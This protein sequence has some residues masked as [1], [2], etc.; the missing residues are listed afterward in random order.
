VVDENGQQKLPG[1]GRLKS[2]I[3]GAG[4]KWAGLDMVKRLKALREKYG[5]TY[6]IVG[7]G[8][9]M[10]PADFH[11][12]LAA[13]ADNVQSATATIWNPRLAIEIKETL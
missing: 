2:G 13:G 6:E 7:V 9:V 11:E 12:Y 5:Y 3:C 1:K 4:I 10:N 8:G